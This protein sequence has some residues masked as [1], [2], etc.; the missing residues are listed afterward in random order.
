MESLSDQRSILQYLILFTS[1]SQKIVIN[2][3]WRL[4]Q[5][6]KATEE[7]ACPERSPAQLE[8]ALPPSPLTCVTQFNKIT[9]RQHSHSP[10]SYSKNVH[11]V[12]LR[13]LKNSLALIDRRGFNTELTDFM[14]Q[15]MQL[16]QFTAVWSNGVCSSAPGISACRI[17]KEETGLLF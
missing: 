7:A 12:A 3:T 11:E 13:D 2:L 6:H 8:A 14:T 1:M 5:D 15:Y 16:K 17:V 10:C 9:T 4:R